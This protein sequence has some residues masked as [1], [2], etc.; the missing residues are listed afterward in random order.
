[1]MHSLKLLMRKYPGI[2][3]LVMRESVQKLIIQERKTYCSNLKIIPNEL[4]AM[5]YKKALGRF[6]NDA[7]GLNRRRG[8]LNNSKFIVWGN[9]AFI[10]AIKDV[11]I[12]EEILVSLVKNIGKLLQRMIFLSKS[13]GFNNVEFLWKPSGQDGRI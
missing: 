13:Y 2:K 1:M 9:G 5:P 4:G 11:D 10:Q 3:N 12:D 6:A 8:L 7:S